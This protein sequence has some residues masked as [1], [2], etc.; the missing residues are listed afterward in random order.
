MIIKVELLENGYETVHV[1][2][3]YPA[4]TVLRLNESAAITSDRGMARAMSDRGIRVTLID[5]GYFSLPPHEYGFIGGSA[6][7][8]GNSVYFTGR[9]DAHPDYEKI[10]RAIESE[11]MKAVSLSSDVPVDVGGILFC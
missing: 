4:C 3:G 2:Q 5:S 11:G 9:I 10:I 8:D 6:G 7:T 1:K